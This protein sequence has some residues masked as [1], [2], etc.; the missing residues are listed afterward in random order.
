MAKKIKIIRLEQGDEK[1][2]LKRITLKDGVL[3]IIP[4]SKQ[5]RYTTQ[6]GV[7]RQVKALL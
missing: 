5:W 7:Y 6:P 2:A 4:T 3:K 1:D